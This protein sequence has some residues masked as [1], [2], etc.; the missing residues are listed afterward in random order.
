MGTRAERYR[1]N[2]ARISVLVADFFCYVNSNSAEMSLI[3]E[4]CRE[5]LVG[6]LQ[7]L[8]F[9]NYCDPTAK[10]YAVMYPLKLA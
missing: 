6:V 7:F 5:C 3:M 1:P 9:M 4:L 2:T 10:H 8:F